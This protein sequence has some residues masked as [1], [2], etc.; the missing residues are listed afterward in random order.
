MPLAAVLISGFK[1]YITKTCLYNFDPIKPYFYIV[2]LGFIGYI[3]YFPYF[4]KKKTG[5]GYSLKRLVK[6][7]LTST[8]NLFLAEIWKYQNF[9]QKIF[10][11]CF[12][13]FQYIWIGVFS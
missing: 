12:L 9:Y 7:V 3:Y 8:H 11:F 10:S 13:N 1:G 4:A 5:C 2:K 6:A